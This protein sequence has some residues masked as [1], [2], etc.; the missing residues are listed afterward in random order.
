MRGA[1]CL[2]GGSGSS[3][4]RMKESEGLAGGS[5]RLQLALCL[6]GEGGR[7]ER[8]LSHKRKDLPKNI[9]GRYRVAAPAACPCTCPRGLPL[10]ISSHPIRHSWPTGAAQS[11]I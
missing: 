1:P 6:P 10:L 8:S 2:P 9:P 3:L 5:R 4:R 7:R 11:P